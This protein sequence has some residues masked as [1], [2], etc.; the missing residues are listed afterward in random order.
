[1]GKKDQ[2]GNGIM[3]FKVSVYSPLG[4]LLTPDTLPLT[5]SVQQL[6]AVQKQKQANLDISN[7]EAQPKE[8]RIADLRNTG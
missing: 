1:M 8:C 4:M 7:R 5:F 3:C 2:A 6:T